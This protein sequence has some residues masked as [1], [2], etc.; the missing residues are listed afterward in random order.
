MALLDMPRRRASAGGL[1]RRRREAAVQEEAASR[2]S[3][4]LAARAIQ[5]TAASDDK[6]DYVADALK[7]ILTRGWSHDP[8]EPG[9][10]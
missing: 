8:L 3:A 9:K 10:L 4:A 2:Q 7:A 6:T 1:S 5:G